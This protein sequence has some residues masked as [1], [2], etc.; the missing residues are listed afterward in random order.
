MPGIRLE[1][2]LHRTREK[3][4]F[5]FSRTLF[6]RP[7]SVLKRA[8]K[9]SRGLVQFMGKIGPILSALKRPAVRVSPRPSRQLR[10]KTL[11]GVAWSV[12]RISTS[13]MQTCGG[14]LAMKT[15]VSAMSSPLNGVMPL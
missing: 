5:W 1:L 7:S 12:G 8:K 9:Y 4:I 2:G 6:R 15:R 3:A 11:A 14:L 13:S 10:R